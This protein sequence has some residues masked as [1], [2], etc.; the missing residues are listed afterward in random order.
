MYVTHWRMTENY[1]LSPC[2]SGMFLLATWVK[3]ME[4]IIFWKIYWQWESFPEKIINILIYEL[5]RWTVY[6]TKQNRSVWWKCF[7]KKF[8]CVVL[9]FLLDKYTVLLDT[10]CELLNLRSCQ[11]CP[12]ESCFLPCCEQLFPLSLLYFNSA[13]LILLLKAWWKKWKQM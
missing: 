6:K 10:S 5:N 9:S 13:A 11:R 8:G 2:V 12:L 4:Q 1:R 7:L 3:S